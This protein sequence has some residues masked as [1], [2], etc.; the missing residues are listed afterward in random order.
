MSAFSDSVKRVT[1]GGAAPP[2]QPPV[3]AQAPLSAFEAAKQRVTAQKQGAL[4]P[5]ADREAALMKEYSKPQDVMPGNWAGDALIGMGSGFTNVIQ[6]I[7]NMTGIHAIP[8]T[9]FGIDAT[10]EGVAEKKRMDRIGGLDDSTAGSIGEFAGEMAALA[11]LGAVGG[12]ARLGSVATKLPTAMKI[13]AGVAEGAGAGAILADPNSRGTGAALGGVLGGGMVGAGAVG[14]RLFKQGLG[15]MSPAAK[16]ASEYITE[17]TGKRSFLPL[18][19]AADP[20]GGATSA[21][22]HAFGDVMS[23]MPT[24]KG[25]VDKQLR[26][27]SMD[28]FEADLRKALSF[29]KGVSD[30][31]VRILRETNDMQKAIESTI[32]KNGKLPA[33]IRVLDAAARKAP[34]GKYSAQNLLKAAEDAVGEGRLT[35]IPFRD[36][37]INRIKVLPRGDSTAAGQST[38]FSRDAIRDSSSIV[39]KTLD[40][41]PLLGTTIS[42]K[43]FQNFLIGN[44]A[45]QQALRKAVDS[46]NGQQ[47]MQ[48]VSAIRR[49]MSGQGTENDDPERVKQMLQSLRGN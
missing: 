29:N 10:D 4:A 43:G 37:A 48:V 15:K 23:L 18:T 14:S 24:A 46:G 7:G 41:I 34:A 12:A 3:Q 49:A 27:V 1:G 33:G 13:L 28:F 5:R 39:G 36:E 45:A 47:A 2:E 6:G 20:A 21:R 8:R 11:P 44:T 32:M 22:T 25:A 38:V 42:S 31:A 40:L 30:K 19:T 17:K 26:D 9:L 35:G 16:E